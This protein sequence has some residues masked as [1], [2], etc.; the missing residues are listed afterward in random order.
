MTGAPYP[1]G[2]GPSIE[3]L[4][5]TNT[6]CPNDLPA[7]PVAKAYNKKVYADTGNTIHDHLFPRDW[8]DARIKSAAKCFQQAA[9]N[10]HTSTVYQRGAPANG[11]ATSD[12]AIRRDDS[13]AT[14]TASNA[15]T[16]DTADT[17][18]P[19]GP[20]SVDSLQI[21]I[22]GTAVALSSGGRRI[23]SRR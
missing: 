13:P 2:A 12:V 11:P 3:V 22:S 6:D 9:V 8:L 21:G 14:N 16:A 1:T 7:T 10:A 19:C 15:D 4:D 5:N 20:S 18:N 17:A 23:S